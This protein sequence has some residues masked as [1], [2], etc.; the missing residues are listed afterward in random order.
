M[1][2]SSRDDEE[3]YIRGKEKSVA[4]KGWHTDCRSDS[5]QPES[6]EGNRQTIEIRHKILKRQTKCR[7]RGKPKSEGVSKCMHL[8]SLR[9]HY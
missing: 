2:Q 4:G 9:R 1:I 6:E 8:S 3:L 5:G 7:P